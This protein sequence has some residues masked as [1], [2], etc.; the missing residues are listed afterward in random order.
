MRLIADTELERAQKYI[1][2]LDMFGV[3]VQFVAACGQHQLRISALVA[4]VL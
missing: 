3:V 1:P 4:Q 2:G